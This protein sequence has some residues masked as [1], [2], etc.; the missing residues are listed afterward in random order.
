[1]RGIGRFE[2]PMKKEPLVVIAGP[3][4][5]ESLSLALEVAHLLREESKRWGFAFYF[6]GSFDKANRSSVHS[7]RGPGLSK[8]LEI[9]RRVREEV[10]VPVTTDV[11]ET[12]QVK[13]VAQVADLIQIPAFLS[14][15]TELLLAA[16]QSGRPVNVKKGQFLAPE[17]ADRIAEK[18]RAGGCFQYF[19]T[20]RG[21][22]F[23]YRDLVV[24]MRGIAIMKR[25]GHRVIFDATHSVQRPAGLGNRSDG[26]WRLA[27]VL[28]RAAVAAGVDGLFLESHPDPSQALSDGPCMIPTRELPAF[29]ERISKV[30]EATVAP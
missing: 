1:V 6:K 15:Q 24:D 25:A 12:W 17:D 5:L 20:E 2:R 26:D 8:G 11:H 16:A 7:P 18:L 10:G 14:R 4:V 23:G 28:A 30:Y 3:C 22:C 27:P 9:L 19:I 29:F 21:S 13:E